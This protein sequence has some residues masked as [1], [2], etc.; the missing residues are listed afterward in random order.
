MTKMFF[1]FGHGFGGT[2]LLADMLDAVQGVDC[3]HERICPESPHGM[4]THYLAVYRGEKDPKEIVL[5]E[6]APLVR[7]VLASGKVF[8]E[9]NGQL[10]FYVGGIHDVWP[11]A[12]FIYMTRNPREQIRTSFNTGM[13][14]YENPIFKGRNLWWWPK[15]RPDDPY[16]DKWECMSVV[17]KCA[18]MWVFVNDFFMEQMKRIPENQIFHY[19]F[20]E[21]I[22]GRNF[23]ELCDFLNINRA[24][25]KEITR[26]VSKKRA[27][28]A[29]RA[30][31]PLPPWDEMDSKTKKSIADIAEKTATKIG[32]GGLH[33]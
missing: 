33:A 7:R 6:R 5:E 29:I 19:R 8:G 12:K 25:R 1:G 13:F 9:I 4:F 24:N 20:E 22:A 17:E 18:W 31:A 10:G 2:H 16:A 26:I 27:K 32:Y 15:P 21:M 11:D 3:K 30:T 28:T 14:D 23:D